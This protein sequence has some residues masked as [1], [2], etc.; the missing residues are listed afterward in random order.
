MSQILSPTS[1][2]AE[3][4]KKAVVAVIAHL[5]NEMNNLNKHSYSSVMP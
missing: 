2:P 1:Y 4:E 5:F 3:L